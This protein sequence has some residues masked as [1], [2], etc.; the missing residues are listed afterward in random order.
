M[1]EEPVDAA[2]T[3]LLYSVQYLTSVL[4]GVIR[5]APNLDVLA[6]SIQRAHAQFETEHA[7]EGRTAPDS[8]RKA[9]EMALEG[10]PR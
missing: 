3:D 2:L 7:G 8:V 9:I 5:A 1:K 4:A 10:G 6:T